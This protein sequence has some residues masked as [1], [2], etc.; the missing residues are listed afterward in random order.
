MKKDWS[1]YGVVALLPFLFVVIVYATEA[2]ARNSFFVC[3]NSNCNESIPANIWKVLRFDSDGGKSSA[4][5]PLEDNEERKVIAL[6]YS[7]RMTW[8]F[9][10]EIFLYVCIGSLA[11]ASVLTAQLFPQLG[12]LWAFGVITLSSIVGLFFYGHPK[13]HMAIFLT[14]FGK[15]ITADVPA[16]SQITNIL[17]SLGNAAVF[18]LLIASCATLLPYQDAS[19]DASFPGGMKQLSRR[20]KYLRIILYAGTVLLVTAILLKESIYQWALAYTPQDDA[21]ETARN[22]VT[23]LLTLEGGFYT[24][25]LAA[26]YLPAALVL[27]R[28]AQLLVGP[29]LDEAE[30]ETKLKEYGMNFSLKESLPRILAI[31]GPFLTGP[32]AELLTGKF[33]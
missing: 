31:L 20:M 8:Y 21:I 23:S 3:N 24:L 11:I 19:S 7:G 1:N 16:I 6:R 2:S 14:I 12:I 22:F 29:S 18:S 25:V 30:E 32:V 13:I 15:A 5:G 26:A 27:Q 17:N 28:R 33:L 10:G 4:T 9:L